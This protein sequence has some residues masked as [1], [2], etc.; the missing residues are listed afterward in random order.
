MTSTKEKTYLI[1]FVAAVSML[2]LIFPDSASAKKLFVP[3]TPQ[4][5]FGDWRQ[6]WQD[7]CEESTIVMVDNFYAGT[8]I[9]K[10]QGRDQIRHIL[11]LKKNMYGFSLDENAEKIAGIIN[12]FLPWEAEIVANPTIEQ[13]KTEIDE[14]RPIIGLTH[15]RYL[16]NPYFF[17]GGPEYHT[18]VISGYDD[19]TKEFITQEPGTRRGLDYRY[20]Y[21]RIMNAIHDFAPGKKTKFSTPTV[22]FT[23]KYTDKSGK[24]DGDNDGLIKDQELMYGSILWLADSDGDGYSD[25]EEVAAGHSPTF[26]RHKAKDGDLLKSPTNPKV[27]IIQNGKKHH[28]YNEVVFLKHNWKWSNIKQVSDSELASIETGKPITT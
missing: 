2:F 18:I 7:A 4:A 6:P 14:G 21:D 10:E 20:S 23:K 13:I 17:D 9:T 3:F 12:N 8:Q 24:T 19:E 25:G 22:I 11:N 28:I 27:Y 5:P 1:F 15:G 16:Y 26:P